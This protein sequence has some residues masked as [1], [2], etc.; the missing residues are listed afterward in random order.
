MTEKNYPE[1][2]YKD[3]VYTNHVYQSDRIREFA[4]QAYDLGRAHAADPLEGYSNLTAA[5]K[6][7]VNIDWEK[8]ARRE[9]HMVNKDGLE[10]NGYKMCIRDQGK[11]DAS[12]GWFTNEAISGQR[13]WEFEW[14]WHG[15][16]GWT[17]WVKG[18]IPVKPK[19]ADQLDLRTV[20]TGNCAGYPN[21]E[22]VIVTGDDGLKMARMITLPLEVCADEV[23]VLGTFGGDK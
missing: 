1:E 2:I 4:E 22:F 10:I 20:F 11:L 7:G 16:L 13:P 18:E 21:S 9:I 23:E 14:S 5:I 12:G 19:T 3:A 15:E 8:L 17:L 6:E